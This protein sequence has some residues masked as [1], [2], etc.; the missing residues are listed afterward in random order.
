MAVV[1]NHRRV[2]L[3]V[4]SEHASCLQCMCEAKTLCDNWMDTC[5]TSQR[6]YSSEL[7]K[8]TLVSNEEVGPL[9]FPKVSRL[10]GEF[11]HFCLH[12]HPDYNAL[13]SL[14]S[15]LSIVHQS[16]YFQWTALTI[17]R[18]I[19]ARQHSPHQ[20][21]LSLSKCNPLTWSLVTIK[22]LV[23]LLPSK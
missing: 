6:F 22:H 18:M 16:D 5:I 7:F 21:P 11:K 17:L 20:L 14:S 2:E 13:S 1:T 10:L 23:V 15:Q 9:L 4:S 12:S 19:H 8:S 3:A